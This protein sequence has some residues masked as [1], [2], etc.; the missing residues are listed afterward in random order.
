[1]LT[2]VT[3]RALTASHEQRN[4]IYNEVLESDVIIYLDD[5]FLP[6]RHYLKHVEEEFLRDP[7]IAVATGVL[8]EDR[9]RG[10]G[11]SVENGLDLLAATNLS[12][13]PQCNEVF[14]GYGCN[15]AIRV[16]TMKG[17]SLT[18]DENL[19]LYGWLEDMDFSRRISKYG[20]IVQTNKLSGVHLRSSK[21]AYPD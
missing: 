7:Q 3:S 8:I 20:K 17:N 11:V 4:I 15:M 9:V 5:D 2:F 19:P 10:P 18:F 21:D 16:K 6:N 1:M 13:E 12:A 14:S